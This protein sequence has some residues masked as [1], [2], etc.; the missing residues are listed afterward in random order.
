MEYISPAM[1]KLLVFFFVTTAIL[2]SHFVNAAVSTSD[3]IVAVV[4]QGVITLRELDNRMQSVRRNLALQKITPPSDDVLRS[5]VLDRMILDMVQAQYAQQAGIRVDDADLEK[6]IAQIAEQ[7]KMT[8]PQFRDRL[9]KEGMSFSAFRDDVR[10]EMLIARIRDRE[11]NSKIVVSDAEVTDLMK[12]QSGRINSEYELAQV[13]IPLA[14]NASPEQTEKTR[15]KVETVLRDIANG[16]SFS[17][18]AAK[19]SSSTDA[20]KGGYLGWRPGASLPP[21]FAR[22]LDSLAIGAVTEPIRTPAGVHIFKLLNKRSQQTSSVI[23][24]THVRHILIRTNE[25]VSENEAMQRAHQI[26]ERL[27]NGAKFEELARLYSE[28][29][30]AGKGGDLGWIS[31]G[32]TVPEFEQSMNQLA[33]NQISAPVRTQ[34]GIHIIQVLERRE[35]DIGNDRERY[36]V[37]MELKERKADEQYQEWMTQLRDSAYVRIHLDDK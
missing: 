18:L 20:M 12:N 9:A 36:R 29:A 25:F 26:R 19:Y 16:V 4:N 28:D 23:T 14:E 2:S 15:Q 31:P 33:P 13:L 10:Q 17:S 27:Q 6:A 34:F 24:Q 1:R 5:Q 32:E 11:V 3:R 8:L 21:N 22:M 7:N 35:Q 37:R 30:S